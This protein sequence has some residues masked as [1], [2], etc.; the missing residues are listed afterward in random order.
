MKQIISALPTLC[1]LFFSSVI[2]AF[3]LGS[4]PSA[5]DNINHVEKGGIDADHGVTKREHSDPRPVRPLTDSCNWIRGLEACKN[6]MWAERP[7]LF[8]DLPLMGKEPATDIE[9]LEV[10]KALGSLAHS[11]QEAGVVNWSQRSSIQKTLKWK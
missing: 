6:T 11:I 8:N 9:I 3:L 7:M 5:F 4:C 10:I 2:A 1:W